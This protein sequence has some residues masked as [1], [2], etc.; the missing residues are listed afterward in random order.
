M[1]GTD[2]RATDTERWLPLDGLA[3]GFDEHRLPATDV[4]AGREVPL[5]F[6]GGATVRYRFADDGALDWNAADG[7][8]G[9]EAYTAIEVADGVVLVDLVRSGDQRESVTLVL[10]LD[11]RRATAVTSRLGPHVAGR[12]AVTQAFRPA[13]IG[14]AAAPG[15]GPA[16]ERSL[17]LVGRR[18]LYTY[19]SRH[20]YEHVYLDGHWFTWHC[21]A[22]PERGQ[23]DTDACSTYRIGDDLY[24]FAWR[25]KVI[26]CAAVVVVDLHRLRSTGKLFGATGDGAGT[27]NFTFGARATELGTVTYPAGLDPRRPDGP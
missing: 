5:A 20:A 11:A 14:D 3:P 1:S 2:A 8:S 17:D 6:D 18:V 22:G 12:A 15:P 23:A 24:L 10:D 7:G 25:E 19:S 4:L 27:V 13:V 26:P 21:L 16:H 9:R